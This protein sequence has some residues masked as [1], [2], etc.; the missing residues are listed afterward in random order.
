MPSNIGAYNILSLLGAT[1]DFSTATDSFF[2]FFC[3]LFLFR[4]HMFRVL[5]Q[6]AF[7]TPENAAMN[8]NVKKKLQDSSF[9]EAKYR[10]ELIR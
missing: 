2:S 8:A 4:V 9:E 7:A 5:L 3:F 10:I 1:N 6:S